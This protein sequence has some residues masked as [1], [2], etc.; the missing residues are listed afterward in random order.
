M[1]EFFLFAVAALALPVSAILV[2]HFVTWHLDRELDRSAGKT[3]R[4][5][6][7]HLY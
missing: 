4:Q 1:T 2:S 3:G 6:S 5:E 7:K